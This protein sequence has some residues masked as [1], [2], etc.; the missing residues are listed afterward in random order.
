LKIDYPNLLTPTTIEEIE[1]PSGILVSVPKAIP[2]FEKW[3]GEPVKDTYNNKPVLNFEGKATFAEI[4][5][6]RIFQSAGWNGVWIDTYRQKF[7]TSYWPKDSIELPSEQN[8]LLP[9][10]YKEAGSNK[11]CWDVFCWKGE[12][13]LFAES[14]RQG[15]DKIRDTQRRWLEAAINCGVPLTSFLVV[16]WKEETI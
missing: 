13:Y 4:I 14:K 9:R 12:S 7:R 5:I 2:V 10:I 16:E 3:S 1:L 8:Q 6:L 15:R 11:G